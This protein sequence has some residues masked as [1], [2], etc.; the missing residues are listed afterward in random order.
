MFQV[1]VLILCEIFTKKVSVN[2][3]KTNL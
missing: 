3:I 1:V 2:I